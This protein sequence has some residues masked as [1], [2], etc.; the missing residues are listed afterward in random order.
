MLEAMVAV[1]PE[2]LANAGGLQATFLAHRGAL[3]RFLR[4]RDCDEADDL[5]QELWLKVVGQKSGPI[6]DSISY[7]FQMANNLVLDRHRAAQ[8]RLRREGEWEYQATNLTGH[9]SEALPDRALIAREQLR[10]VEVALSELGGRT[11]VIFLRFRADGVGQRQIAEEMGIS[12]SA[13]EKHLQKAY[14]AIMR[15]QVDA[16]LEVPCRPIPKGADDVGG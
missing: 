11:A 6:D 10:A 14:R 4:A 2:I 12:L 15:L 1:D 8:R 13:V 5:L 9:G 16:E 3:L 7:L